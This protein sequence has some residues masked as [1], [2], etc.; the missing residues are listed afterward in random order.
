MREEPNGALV[1]PAL[2]RLME[3]ERRNPPAASAVAR[4]YLERFPHG[5]YAPLARSLLAP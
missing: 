4:R 1:E 5:A 3:L 2:G